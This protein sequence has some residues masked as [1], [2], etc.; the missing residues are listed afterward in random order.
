[1]QKQ[2]YVALI[3]ACCVFFLGILP[4]PVRGEREQVVAET[5]MPGINV[6]EDET[7]GSLHLWHLYERTDATAA[8]GDEISFV[9]KVEDF[10]SEV[11]LEDPPWITIAVFSE[12]LTETDRVQTFQAFSFQYDKQPMDIDLA[13]FVR[14]TAKLLVNR[15]DLSN[16]AKSRMSV[17]LFR[18]EPVK[19]V[20]IRCGRSLGD[21]KKAAAADIHAMEPSFRELCNKYNLRY[22]FDE[23]KLSRSWYKGQIAFTSIATTHPVFSIRPIPYATISA[24]YEPETGRLSGFVFT[25]RVWQ[26]PPD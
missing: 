6:I 12:N 16:E 9:G 1:M 17:P 8:V 23:S 18:I 24:L 11:R 2:I 21:L 20:P 25:R 3:V 13:G 4:L 15:S 14:F 26:D 5:K 7:P 19:V 10:N 22:N